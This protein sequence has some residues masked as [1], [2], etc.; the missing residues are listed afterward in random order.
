MDLKNILKMVKMHG[1]D[2]GDDEDMVEVVK[3]REMVKMFKI[4]QVIK[5][6][7]VFCLYVFFRAQAAKCGQAHWVLQCEGIREVE[8]SCWNLQAENGVHWIWQKTISSLQSSRVGPEHED[9]SAALYWGQWK[10][11]N[12]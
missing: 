3:L 11:T 6:W 2:G 9:I 5:M 4:V 7:S 8:T 10:E 1:G 12:I